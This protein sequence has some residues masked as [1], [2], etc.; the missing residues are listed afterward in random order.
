MVPLVVVIGDS[1]AGFGQAGK[2]AAVEQ[3]GFEAAPKGFGVGIVV[4]VAA[5]THTLLSPVAGQ[6]IPESGGRVLAALVGMH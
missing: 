2:A 4:A 1:Q 6:Q 3:F 5:P